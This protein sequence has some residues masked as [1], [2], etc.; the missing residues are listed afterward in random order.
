V[1]VD[2]RHRSE[3]YHFKFDSVLPETTT[4]QE[5]FDREHHWAHSAADKSHHDIGDNACKQ[6]HSRQ[7]S[8]HCGRQLVPC[9]LV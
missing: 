6:H 3:P 7:W 2:L 8:S 9:R 4:Q 1:C 5:I